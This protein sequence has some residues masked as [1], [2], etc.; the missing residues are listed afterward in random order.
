MASGLLVRTCGN[1]RVRIAA[2]VHEAPTAKVAVA[3]RAAAL[4][5]KA[6]VEIEKCRCTARTRERENL[7]RNVVVVL[8]DYL[9]FHLLSQRLNLSLVSQSLLCIAL[10]IRAASHACHSAECEAENRDPS[11][12]SE[13]TPLQRHLT[14][15]SSV[16]SR[17]CSG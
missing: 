10:S 15:P 9:H 5:R 11:I 7:L 3:R 14:N 1:V 16:S 6:A 4:Q 8:C 12:C 13:M 17:L 2:T